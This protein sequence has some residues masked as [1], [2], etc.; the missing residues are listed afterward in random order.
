MNKLK[1]ILFDLDGTLIDSSMLILDAFAHTAETHN[2]SQTKDDFFHHLKLGRVKEEIYEKFI[3]SK[4]IHNLIQTHNTFQNQHLERIKIFADVQDVLH[5]FH[6]KG[7]KLGVV[8]TKGKAR[9]EPLLQMH[10]L[11]HYFDTV[12]TLEDITNPKPHPEPILKALE[13]LNVKPE[14]AAMVG[15]SPADIKSGKA[16]GVKTVAVT[17][18]FYGE[19][20]KE[21]EPDYIISNIAGL[22]DLVK[23]L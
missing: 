11:A 10:G 19:K 16:A 18:G 14:E 9:V 4:D 5:T 20:I 22:I 15:D 7:F 23:S 3:D 17:Y 21:L 13:I 8:T 2:L 12:I 1:A 6:E